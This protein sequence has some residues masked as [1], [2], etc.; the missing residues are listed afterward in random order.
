MAMTPVAPQETVRDARIEPR[1]AALQ[2]GETLAII[3]NILLY[4]YT[5]LIY[6]TV[7]SHRALPGKG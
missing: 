6:N 4:A 5:V 3:H 2:S 1:T 7:Y